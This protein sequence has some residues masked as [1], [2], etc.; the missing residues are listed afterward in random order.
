MMFDV[1]DG[2][3]DQISIGGYLAMWATGSRL[4]D[5]DTFPSLASNSFLEIMSE[6]MRRLRHDCD[7]V[8]PAIGAVARFDDRDSVFSVTDADLAIQSIAA[9]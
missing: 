8:V 7:G 4:F 6:C 5:P 3:C 9:R 2:G 1:A